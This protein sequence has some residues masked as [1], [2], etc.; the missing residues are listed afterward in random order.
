MSNAPFPINPDLTSIAIAYRNKSLIAD[1]VLPRVGVNGSVF[2][3]MEYPVGQM[4][5]VPN[6]Q[7]SRRGA[8]NVVE[9]GGTEQESAVRDYGLDDTVPQDDI[10]NAANSS[11]FNPLNTATTGLTNL[12]ELDREVRVANMVFGNTNYQ[13]KAALDANS[14]WDGNNSGGNPVDPIPVIGDALDVPLMRPNIMVLGQKVATKLRQN[15]NIIKAYNGS[16]GD[17]GMVP[18][19][20]LADLF[21]LQEIVVGQSRVNI[22]KPGQSLQIANVWGD[23]A[24][25]IYRNPEA[26]PDRDVTFGL[27]AQWGDRFAGDWFEQNIGLKGGRRVRVGEQVREVIMATDCAYFFEDVL[28][29]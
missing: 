17:T 27:T 15:P 22:A 16:L 18:L 28:T 29:A 14:K 20:F 13:H 6:T 7:V 19:Q 5:T 2:K 4:M 9:F 1:R 25:L 26:R 8:P 12:L 21:E 24:A 10:D 3:W 23:H 11:G